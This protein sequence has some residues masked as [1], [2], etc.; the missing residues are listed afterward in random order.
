MPQADSITEKLLFSYFSGS[1]TLLEKQMIEKWKTEPEN[2][3]FFFTCLHAWEKNNLQYQGDLASALHR[4]NQDLSTKKPA[5]AAYTKEPLP[6]DR[7]NWKR[8]V[9]AASVLLMVAAS[10]YIFR[11]PILFKTYLTAKDATQVIALPDGSKVVLNA[12]S[13]I[14][15]PRFGF[16]RNSRRVMLKGEARFSVVHTPDDKPFVVQ[17][18]SLFQVEVLGT[19]FAVFARPRQTKVLLIRGKVKVHY[20]P[21]N[22]KEKPIVMV[23]GEVVTLNKRQ[24][25]PLVTK[26]ARPE[27][28]AAWPQNRFVFENTSL[29]EI[30]NILWENYGLEVQLSGDN[31]AGQALTGSFKAKNAGEFL[32]GISEVLDIQVS[33]QDKDVIL[34][35]SK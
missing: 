3:K 19:E 27:N 14:Q 30:K 31:L 11:Q 23:P 1:A 18:D 32:K 22:Q 24:E 4:F 20:G 17:T 29:Q 12:H 8:W 5:A 16:G 34:I 7:I 10:G 13:S 33:R 35:N 2:E 6:V 21:A 25:K 15:V 9:A 26:V 28:Y